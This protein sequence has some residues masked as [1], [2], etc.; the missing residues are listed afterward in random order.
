MQN[1]LSM[2]TLKLLHI[3]A[4]TWALQKGV[5]GCTQ[6]TW[7]STPRLDGT[8][9]HS[10]AGDSGTCVTLDAQEHNAACHSVNGYLRF[11]QNICPN[12]GVRHIHFGC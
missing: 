10:S 12:A 1:L 2:T 3:I 6:G 7:S 8:I 4:I 5:T 9:C 11:E